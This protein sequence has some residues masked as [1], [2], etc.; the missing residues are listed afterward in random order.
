MKRLILGIIAVV[1][2]D[3]GF[4][5]Y[6]RVSDSGTASSTAVNSGA[7]ESKTGSASANDQQYSPAW[8]NIESTFPHLKPVDDLPES[9]TPLVTKR[10]SE[11][12]VLNPRAGKKALTGKTPA[13]TI[14]PVRHTVRVSNDGRLR[15]E[16]FGNM[17]V[18]TGSTVARPAKF[19]PPTAEKKSLVAKALPVIKKPWDLMKAVASRLK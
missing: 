13:F 19:P 5:A 11:I 10:R 15:Q 2:L 18:E 6:M 14:E 12:A 9:S 8:D 7:G 17:L 4:V 1:C 16:L 3:L